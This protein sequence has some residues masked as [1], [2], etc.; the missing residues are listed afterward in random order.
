[1]TISQLHRQQL[2]EQ[3]RDFQYFMRGVCAATFIGLFLVLDIMLGCLFSDQILTGLAW[4]FEW[5]NS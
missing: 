4:V 1:M 2:D 3:D 5:V